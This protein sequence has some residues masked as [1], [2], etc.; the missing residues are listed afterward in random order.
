[1]CFRDL[2]IFTIASFIS[3]F[4]GRLD[5]LGENGM[6][7]IEDIV[8]IYDN[9]NFDTEVLVASVRSTQH[10]IDAAVI[11]ADVATLPPKV[12]IVSTLE[13]VILSLIFYN[14]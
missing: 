3:P 13:C 4:V 1:M 5:D 2:D 7:L 9:Y 8:D 10:I 6:D 11:G 12:K 14:P